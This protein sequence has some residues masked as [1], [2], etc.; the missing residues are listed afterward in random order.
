MSLLRGDEW[1]CFQNA[2]NQIRNER[3]P[4]VMLVAESLAGKQIESFMDTVQN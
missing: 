1:V 4:G 2:D 3:A